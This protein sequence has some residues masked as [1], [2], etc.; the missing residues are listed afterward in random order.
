MKTGKLIGIYLKSLDRA[1]LWNLA[2]DIRFAISMQALVR[3]PEKWRILSAF[4]SIKD[5]MRTVFTAQRS[6]YLVKLNFSMFQFCFSESDGMV[7]LW[8]SEA[9]DEIPG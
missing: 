5:A 9:G 7:A 8:C 2:I 6:A 4:Y 1:L 3:M